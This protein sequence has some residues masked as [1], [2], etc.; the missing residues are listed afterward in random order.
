MELYDFEWHS[1]YKEETSEFH[2][3]ACFVVFELNLLLK[4][5]NVNDL[6]T[7]HDITK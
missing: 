6:K 7:G 5:K 4:L 2:S 3:G 1:P